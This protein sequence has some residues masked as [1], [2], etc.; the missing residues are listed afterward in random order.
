VLQLVHAASLPSTPTTREALARLRD[1]GLLPADDAALLIRADRVWRTVQGLL[2]ITYGRQPAEKLSEAAAATLLRA[3]TA[4]GA[5]AVDVA[6]LHATFA[7]LAEQVRACFA[8]HVGEID[9]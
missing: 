2:R 8:R 6:Q 3:A 9:G 5:P 4:A 1:E 7:A